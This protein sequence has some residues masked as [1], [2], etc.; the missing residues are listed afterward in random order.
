MLVEKFLG[1][2]KF[3]KCF[4]KTRTCFSLAKSKAHTSHSNS[5]YEIH[6][7]NPRHCLHFMNASQAKLPKKRISASDQAAVAKI[8]QEKRKPGSPLDHLPANIEI[9]T[10]F[11]ERAD[12]S[13]DNQHIAF[14][15]KSFGDAMVLHLKDR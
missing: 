2:L 4:F 1:Q 8:Q 6:R 13:P 10:P 7:S 11:G 9:L 14:M 5:C 12:F 3:Q 15:G